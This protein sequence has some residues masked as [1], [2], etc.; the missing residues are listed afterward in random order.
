M[1]SGTT[2][3]AAKQLGCQWLGFELNPTFYQIAVDRMNGVDQNGQIDLLATDYEQLDLFG[4]DYE[5]HI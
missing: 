5:K 3:L 1:G 2:T 4:G